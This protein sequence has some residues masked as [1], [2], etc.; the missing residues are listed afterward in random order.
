MF[1][2]IVPAHNEEMLIGATVQSIG[3]SAQACGADYEIIV[4][5]DS[6]TD[7]TGRIAKAAGARVVRASCRQ[8]AGA[9]NAGARVAHGETLVFVDADTLINANAVRGM[10]DALHGGAIGGGARF[11]FDDP[12]PTYARILL[13][14]VQW[15]NARMG[16]VSGCFLFCTRSAFE[17]VGGFNEQV[18]AAEEAFISR[19]LGRRGSLVTVKQPVL[20]SGRKLRTYS[21]GEILSVLLS[22]GLRGTKGLRNRQK[23][24]L[25]Y[26]RRREDPKRV[27]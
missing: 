10:M 23:L 24:D 25:W 19:A 9:R 3:V 14:I 12:V 11:R 27:D 13:P 7:D 15:L 22:L 8:I 1:S 5:D 6:S 20:T 21:A 17:A 16:I 26:G 18:Y 4:V 2:F